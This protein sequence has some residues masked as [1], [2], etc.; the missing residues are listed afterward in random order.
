M[1][2]EST[3]SGEPAQVEEFAPALGTVRTQPGSVEREN[4][5]PRDAADAARVSGSRQHVGWRETQRRVVDG[6]EN[7]LG[8]ALDD[9]AALGVED[10]GLVAA[11]GD[12]RADPVEVAAPVVLDDPDTRGGGERLEICP[13]L[14]LAVSAPPGADGQ[15]LGERIQRECEHRAQP[16]NHE[17]SA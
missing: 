16:G 1:P 10:M 8:A 2:R 5:R 15:R 14:A 9:V 17:Q 12:H 7:P 13:A 11:G 3:S 4:H 6:L